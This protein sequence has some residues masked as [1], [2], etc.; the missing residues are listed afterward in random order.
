MKMRRWQM[1]CAAMLASTASLTA[2]LDAPVTETPEVL[3]RAAM[4]GDTSAQ[5]KLA[6]AHLEGS[7][8]L[9]KDPAKAAEWFR[10]AAT[11]GLAAAQ[12]NLGVLLSNG[13]DVPRNDKEAALWFSAAA[14]NGNFEAQVMMV[15][16][17]GTGRGVEK[18]PAMALWWDMIARRTLELKTA[19]AAGSPPK[20]GALRADGAAEMT[21]KEGR[22]VWMLPDGTKETQDEGGVR[23]LEHKDGAKS[24]VQRDGS[25]ETIFPNGLREQVSVEGRRTLTDGKGNVEIYEIDGSHSVEGDGQTDGGRK[26]RVRDT[27]GV[28]GKRIG[29]RV[30][31]GDSSYEERAD[32]T[33]IVETDVT[34]EDGTPMIITEQVGE[35]G[36]QSKGKL[37]RADNG[38]GPKGSEIWAVRR[39]LHLQGGIVADV[40]EKYS[41]FGLY[42][43][44]MLSQT[45]EATRMPGVIVS[46]PRITATPPPLVMTANVPQSFPTSVPF[47]PFG[48][49]TASTGYE[50]PK[51]FAPAPDIA[52][53]LATL[54]KAELEARNFAG[55]TE[56][57]FQRAKTGSAAYYIPLT[58]TPQ[59]ATAAPAW[60]REKT[61]SQVTLHEEQLLAIADDRSS[62]V[63]LGPF[64]S[65]VIKQQPWKHAETQHFIIHYVGDA[66]AR[67]T[68]QYIEGVFTVLTQLL[69]LDT[70]RGAT[71]SHV[72]IFP[73][74]A[75]KDFTAKN[76]L[77]PQVE[78]FAFKTELLLGASAARADRWEATKVICHEVTH[79]LVTRFY[80]GVRPPLWLNEG[81]AEYIAT[82][83]MRTKGGTATPPRNL[84]KPDAQIDVE[85][86]FTRVRYGEATSPDRLGAFYANS[87]KAVQVLFEKLPL[88]GF[89]RFFNLIVAGN[90]PGV[91]F[92]AAYGKQCDGVVAF[93]TILNAQ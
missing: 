21:D 1:V 55:A 81:M 63:P 43:Q 78:G 44:E 71:K 19:I 47:N 86:L 20:P 88:D 38:V 83:T 65:E 60:L 14:K 12:Y 37:R 24:T 50:D 8:A 48:R 66:E 15:R 62:K 82:R 35:D 9:P 92:N 74:G 91:S 40:I 32:G 41:G 23:H 68:V 57:D 93:R 4:F 29:H 2:G 84:I 87:Q 59:S 77:P 73:E 13:K 75:W 89:P 64:G 58:A 49:T 16:F 26:V 67:L 17:L 11:A 7:N 56:A 80:P 46:T 69:N 33:K 54:A 85:K 6:L 3:Q 39:K 34:G 10:K 30:K 31:S 70:A 25:W 42:A 79:A 72:F 27:F 18:N 51:A 61:I 36:Q 28:D 5:F 76:G 52:P 90:E 22:K 45:R 53:M